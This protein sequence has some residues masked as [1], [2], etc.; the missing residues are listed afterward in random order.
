MSI[1]EVQTELLLNLPTLI[2]LETNLGSLLSI[3]AGSIS[4]DRKGEDQELYWQPACLESQLSLL[5]AVQTSQD[6]FLSAT[7]VGDH[8][9]LPS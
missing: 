8:L 7:F 9:Y 3:A 5:Y 1:T 4:R 6:T 2:A